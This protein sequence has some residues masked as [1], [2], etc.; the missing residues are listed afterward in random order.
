MTPT[1]GFCCIDKPAGPT[2]RDV[3]DRVGR[4]L[5]TRKVGHAGTLDPLATGVLVIA[6]GKATKLI[7]YVQR[8]A[9][10]YRAA[11]RLGA[12]SETDDVQGTVTECD[13]AALP[14]REEVAAALAR[15]VG[16]VMQRPP[17]FSALRVGGRRA[18]E[19][20][21]AGETVVLDARPVRI[22][23]ITLDR[24]DDL[25]VECT[26]RCGGGTYIRSIARDLG[27]TLGCGG[28]MTSL[29]RTAV[30]EF[31]LERAVPLDD[32]DRHVFDDVRLPLVTGVAEV[33][34]ITVDAEGRSHFRMGRR[35]VASQ[36]PDGTVAAVF[37]EAGTM[38]GIAEPAEDGRWKVLKGGFATGDTA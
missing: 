27:E 15:Q 4:W 13:V 17:A 19:L 9:K 3:V 1:A 38:L 29:R 32:L 18:Y 35:F 33:P 23:A 14:T 12:T 37:D 25:T 10:T 8:G 2:S 30:G 22:D 31:T 28:L 21:R 7:E 5:G 24:Y 6:V 11:F 36:E 26:V 34:R 16:E 20:A